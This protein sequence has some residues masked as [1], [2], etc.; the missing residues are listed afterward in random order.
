MI[1]FKFWLKKG[2]IFGGDFRLM[3]V[4]CSSTGGWQWPT[5]P[6]FFFIFFNNNY[7]VQ[8][9]NYFTILSYKLD[10]LSRFYIIV[11]NEIMLP[12]CRIRLKISISIYIYRNFR[13][14]SM[15][16]RIK[17]LVEK[18]TIGVFF[19]LWNHRAVHDGKQTFTHFSSCFLFNFKILKNS[20]PP[21]CLSCN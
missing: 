12:C 7:S 18:Y 8:S 21:Y 20:K 5:P 3:N 15:P 9:W 11:S 19:P 10:V 1:S 6:F 14:E 16:M 4:T 17:T 13:Y 2:T